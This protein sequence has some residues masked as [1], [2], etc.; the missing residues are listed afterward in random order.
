MNAHEGQAD[1]L[2]VLAFGR[3]MRDHGRWGAS[4]FGAGFRTVTAI[5]RAG[6][7]YA[8]GFAGCSRTSTRLEVALG[9]SNYGSA[10][11]FQHGRSWA[12]MVNRA[13]EWVDENGLGRSVRFAGASDIELG[14]NGPGVSRQWVRGYD[15]VTLWPFYNY[16]DAAACPPRGNC[17]GVWTPEDVWFVSWGAASAWPLPQ[18]YTGSGIMAEQWYRL[19]LYSYRRHGSRMTI[20]GALSQRQ[21][22]R[23]SNDPCRGINNTPIRAWRQ[24]QRWLNRDPRTAQDLRW[25]S[26]LRWEG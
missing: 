11:G 24:L 16:G 22:C 26:D 25:L 10:V 17:L 23:Q 2:V 9:T 4:L 18:V 8:R 7:A 21:A 3:P 20:A 13:N 15:A 14:W 5:Q 6:Q 1:A 12:G 19:S